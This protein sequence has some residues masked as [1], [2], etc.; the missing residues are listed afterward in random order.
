MVSQI[1]S[2]EA[3]II[4]PERGGQPMADNNPA[5]LLDSHHSAEHR[6]DADSGR[7]CVCGGRFA[8]VS[9]TR[10]PAQY[11]SRR[12]GGIWAT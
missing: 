3:E 5:V 6:L 9:G 8:W 4:Y 12:N 11:G 10:Q 1:Q 7:E 2:S